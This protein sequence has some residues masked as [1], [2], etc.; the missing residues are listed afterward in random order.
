MPDH[1]NFQSL[2][3]L[4]AV[5]SNLCVNTRLWIPRNLVSLQPWAGGK[6]SQP[7]TEDV[8]IKT[9]LCSPDMV[10]ERGWYSKTVFCSMLCRKK[11]LM[12]LVHILFD[13]YRIWIKRKQI[14]LILF[15]IGRSSY[16]M[17]WNFALNFQTVLE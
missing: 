12:N 1:L 9:R 15:N 4:L 8:C 10:G 14:V 11:G 7:E 3:T 16:H 5:T 6:S 17:L 13:Y 2:L